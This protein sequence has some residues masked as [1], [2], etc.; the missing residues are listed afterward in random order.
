MVIGGHS[1]CVPLEYPISQMFWIYSLNFAP[2]DLFPYT[3]LIAGCLNQD[4]FYKKLTMILFLE[5]IINQELKNC[6]VSLHPIDVT[7]DTRG[8]RV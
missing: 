4:F 3:P 5:N 7:I 8:F 1:V 2:L 6:K